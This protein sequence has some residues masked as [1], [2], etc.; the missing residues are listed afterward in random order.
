M[1]A[2][3]PVLSSKSG[4]IVAK[5]NRFLAC[6][7]L[8]LLFR[9]MLLFILYVRS[10]TLEYNW[11]FKPIRHQQICPPLSPA[12]SILPLWTSADAGV[13]HPMK[14]VSLSTDSFTKDLSRAY[15]MPGLVPGTEDQD[16]PSEYFT[17]KTP[18]FTRFNLFSSM[19]ALHLHED[20]LNLLLTI[21]S[22]NFSAK[23]SLKDHLIF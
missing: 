8:Y 3:P 22:Y 5:W 12:I 1:E 10:T 15:S 6:T 20:I 16:L 18:F 19:E 2:P 9:Q 14:T 17:N 21:K 11:Q 7:M 4:Q 23:R 13:S